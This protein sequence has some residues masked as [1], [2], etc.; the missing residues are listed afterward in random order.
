MS[1]IKMQWKI[2]WAL[3]DHGNLMLVQLCLNMK[4]MH[5]HKYIKGAVEYLTDI[6]ITEALSFT[7]SEL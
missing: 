4:Y 1:E 2:M 7:W 5:H 6:D 3:T